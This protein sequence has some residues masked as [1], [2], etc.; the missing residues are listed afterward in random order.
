MVS[1]RR[2]PPLPFPQHAC[3]RRTGQINITFGGSLSQ[4]RGLAAASLSLSADPNLLLFALLLAADQEAIPDDHRIRPR[5][6]TFESLSLPPPWPTMALWPLLPFPPGRL[7]G[8]YGT[9]LFPF[10]LFSGQD[11]IFLQVRLPS[12]QNTTQ[13]NTQPSTLQKS[14]EKDKG[15]SVW[16]SNIKHKGQQTGQVWG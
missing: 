10:F 2:R 9:S 14:T 4:P 3:L 12:T 11:I 6:A 16:M 7:P 15:P 8:S 13:H 5:R 1:S